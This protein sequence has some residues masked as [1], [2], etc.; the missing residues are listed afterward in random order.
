MRASR[1]WSG[2]PSGGRHRCGG[3]RRGRSLSR[4]FRTPL[5]P[6]GRGVGGKGR[7]ATRLDLAN[8]LVSKEHPLTARVFVNRLWKL[9]FGQGLVTSLEDFGA[10]GDWPSHPELL[11]W[12]AVEFIDSGWDVK[13]LVRLIVTSSAYRQVSTA[14]PA[15]QHRDP[16]NRLLARQGRFRLDAELSKE[17]PRERLTVAE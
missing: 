9:F 11:D 12:L 14:T 7:R 5:A 3:G 17:L 8:W 1:P 2:S 6:A 10:Q 16:Y 15:L 4:H 13:Y